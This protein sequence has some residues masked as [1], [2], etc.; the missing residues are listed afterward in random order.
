MR[1]VQYSAPAPDASTTD[2]VSSE[3]PAPGPGQVAI[4]VEWAGINFKDVMQRRGDPGYVPSWP[5]VPGLEVSGRV[6]AAGAGTDPALVG[7]DVVAI[8]SDG[9]LAEV[10]V[11]DARLVAEIPA[12]VELREAAAVPGQ[13][14]T[15]VLLLE[16][17]ARVGPGDSLLVHSAAGGVGAA[18]AQLARHLGAS[19]LIGIVGATDRTAAARS[20]GYEPVSVRG[21]V[22]PSDIHDVTSG[23]GIDVVLD[24]QGTTMLDF[25][26][27]VTAPG[28][29]VIVFGNAAGAPMSDPPPISTLMGKGVQLGGFSL[30]A[31]ISRAPEVVAGGLARAL[32]YL[33]AGVLSPRII[34]VENLE[35]VPAVHDALAAGSGRGKYVVRAAASQSRSA[36]GLRRT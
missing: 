23:G 2:V 22:A 11:A 32:G 8:T 17:F 36:E 1:A 21:V 9:G 13:L 18:V 12:R 33:A 30:A 26:L 7:R 6:T 24:P 31:L 4:D 28:G 25:D 29:R 16:D 19:Q 14:V 5:F 27:D 15:A 20:L 35:A 10:A 3:P 34:E